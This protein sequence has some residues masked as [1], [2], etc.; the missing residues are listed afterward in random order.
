MK[1]YAT[2]TAS[3]LGEIL[4][5]GNAQALCGLW[6]KGQRYEPEIDPQWIWDAAPLKP[7]VDAV[8]AYFSGQAL[9]L[10]YP[11]QP[12][13]T[14]FQLSVWQML[15]RIPLGATRTY[16]DVAQSLGKPQAVRAVGSAIGKNP[17]SLVIPCHRVVGS[18]GALTGYAGGLKRKA[19][20]LLHEQKGYSLSN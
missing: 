3:P 19:W 9:R 12:K 4:L 18:S 5:V 1:K 8:M 16:M 6:F 7:A 10:N 17:I 13:G 11:V 14:A 20:L 15:Q 2:Y